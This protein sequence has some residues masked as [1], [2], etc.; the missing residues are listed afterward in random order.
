MELYKSKNGHTFTFYT[1]NEG[2]ETECEL[3]DTGD[4]KTE[5]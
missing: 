4:I 5:W 1:L 3:L 2:V